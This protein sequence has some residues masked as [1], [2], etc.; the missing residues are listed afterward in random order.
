MDP[1]ITSGV[2]GEGGAVVASPPTL[3]FTMEQRGATDTPGPNGL[4]WTPWT[5]GASETGTSE[6]LPALPHWPCSQASTNMKTVLLAPHPQTQRKRAS[7]WDSPYLC[8]PSSENS[9]PRKAKTERGNK[10]GRGRETGDWEAAYGGEE[11]TALVQRTKIKTVLSPNPQLLTT[12]KC[13]MLF[14]KLW[15]TRRTNGPS[16]LRCSSCFTMLM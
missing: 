1:L 3:L 14:S 10:R 5:G 15:C 6:A 4:D 9:H 2:C 12:A 13:S 8:P 11:L 7:F 16:L